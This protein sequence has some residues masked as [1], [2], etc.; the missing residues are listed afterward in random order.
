MVRPAA[1]VPS[2]ARDADPLFHELTRSICRRVVDVQILLRG[3]ERL[4]AQA[5]TPP[6]RQLSVR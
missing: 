2:T 4:H 5:L 6:V 1:V 3:R